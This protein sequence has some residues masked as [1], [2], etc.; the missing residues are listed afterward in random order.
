LPATCTGPDGKDVLCPS[1]R[2]EG[3]APLFK[4]FDIDRTFESESAGQADAEANLSA[5]LA[6]RGLASGTAGNYACTAR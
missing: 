5:Y 3:N 2:T 4:P 6:A 1:I